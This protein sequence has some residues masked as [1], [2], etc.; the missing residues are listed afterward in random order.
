LTPSRRSGGKQSANAGRRKEA[1]PKPLEILWLVSRGV[2]AGMAI[3][4]LWVIL[5][6]MVSE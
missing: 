5:A 3:D 6:A 4:A 1:Q 2:L